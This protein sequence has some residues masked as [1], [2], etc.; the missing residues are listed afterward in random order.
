MGLKVVHPFYVR[1]KIVKLFLFKH[2]VVSKVN[3]K[4]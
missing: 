2:N 3:F 1:G 4:T